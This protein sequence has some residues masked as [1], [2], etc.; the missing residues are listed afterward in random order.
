M[1]LSGSVT[2][3]VLVIGEIAV[4]RSLIAI[5]IALQKWRAF[6]RPPKFLMAGLV[7]LLFFMACQRNLSD[8]HRKTHY[9]Q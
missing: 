5:V 9:A 7:V 1:T 8:G 4:V 3:F 6:Q 2:I